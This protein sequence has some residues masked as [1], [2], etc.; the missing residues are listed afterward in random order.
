MTGATVTVQH[1]ELQWH[2]V[3]LHPAI[4]PYIIACIFYST[5]RHRHHNGIDARDVTVA[6]SPAA[7]AQH[8]DT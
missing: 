7:A 1:G 8:G 5:S 3:S 4:H 6:N 2:A